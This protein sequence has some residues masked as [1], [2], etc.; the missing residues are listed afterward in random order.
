MNLKIKK[1]ATKK[2]LMNNNQ[3]LQQSSSKNWYRFNLKIWKKSRNNPSCPSEA[4][5]LMYSQEEIIKMGEFYKMIVFV[6]WSIALCIFRCFK[7][8][9]GAAIVR[10]TR[11]QATNVDNSLYRFLLAHLKVSPISFLVHLMCYF[12]R[13]V[14]IDFF[15][16]QFVFILS[17]YFFSRTWCC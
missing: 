13:N 7:E 9:Y 11:D 14:V 4:E 3:V 8:L 10:I 1:K 6:S 12:L 17:Y 15:Y 2:P 5:T 16:F